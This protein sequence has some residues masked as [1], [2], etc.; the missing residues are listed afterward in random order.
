MNTNP[1][2]QPPKDST[3]PDNRLLEVVCLALFVSLFYSCASDPFT[4][5]PKFRK[6]GP[7]EFP[8]LETDGYFRKS[9][10]LAAGYVMQDGEWKSREQ[11]A[12][13]KDDEAF[14]QN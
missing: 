14:L 2:T 11:I 3:V 5:I 6:T 12:K 13:Q 1:T 8:G 4:D 7:A 9:E 10:A